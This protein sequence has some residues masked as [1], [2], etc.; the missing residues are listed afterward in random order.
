M[1][2]AAA[3]AW[4][5]GRRKALREAAGAALMST[6]V[7]KKVSLVP[8]SGRPVHGLVTGRGGPGVRIV[9]GA[10]GSGPDGTGRR[11]RS[12]RGQRRTDRI[13]HNC[14]TLEVHGQHERKPPR[15]GVL[16]HQLGGREALSGVAAEDEDA[17]AGAGD[18]GRV[19][20]AA[21]QLHELV[22]LRHGGGAVA[23]MQ[24]VLGRGEQ[25]LGALHE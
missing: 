20:V 22:G 13:R 4:S 14:S 21:Q 12:L 25:E 16:L 15:G 5:S 7:T 18:D 17:G 24:L 6:S 23:L 3:M 10:Y 19:P 1:P 11:V 8:R 2:S 9:S